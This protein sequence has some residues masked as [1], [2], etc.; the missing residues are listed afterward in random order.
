MVK[1]SN[2]LEFQDLQQLKQENEVMT[3]NGANGALGDTTFHKVSIDSIEDEAWELLRES[4]VYYC[5]S[6]IGTIVAK[7]LTSSNTLNYDL[8]FI[9]D[10]I[11]SST[12][13]LL[14]GEYEIIRNFILHMLQ[15][16]SWEKTMDCHSPGQGLMPASFK[17]R[18]VPLDGDDYATLEALFYSA[19]LCAH[20]ML[21]PEHGSADLLRALNNHLPLVLPQC[22][23]LANSVLAVHSCMH[24]DE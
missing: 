16:Q 6:P 11:P 17:V 2:I 5:G 4:M 24:K 10:F 19:L 1:A 14:K 20:E 8:V 15:L 13:F 18:T 9:R 21:A 12:A 23:F 7:D 3:S 22:R